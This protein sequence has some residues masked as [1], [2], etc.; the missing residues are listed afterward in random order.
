MELKDTINGMIST[1]Y[2]ERLKAEYQQLLIR[3]NK[4]NGILTDNEN[5][6]LSFR[7]ESPIELLES[8]R[9]TMYRY[10]RLLEMRAMREGINLY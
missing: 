8:Q 5:N 2:K 9:Q 7:L 6:K 10:L 3:Y 1:D 4:L